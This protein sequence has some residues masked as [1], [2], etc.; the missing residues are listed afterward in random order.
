MGNPVAE[1]LC[2]E[3]QTN[4]REWGWERAGWI[5]HRARL[6]EIH[7]ND[8]FPSLDINSEII[9][10]KWEISLLFPRADWKVIKL[11]YA[12]RILAE[13][14]PRIGSSPLSSLSRENGFCGIDRGWGGGKGRRRKRL[15]TRRLTDWL[16]SNLSP[17]TV[18]LLIYR[19]Q[20][21]PRSNNKQ[22][23]RLSSISGLSLMLSFPLPLPPSCNARRTR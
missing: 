20:L 22:F 15:L 4:E 23:I 2:G 6:S 1:R 17:L 19:R 5:I 10:D 11:D 16:I 9:L 14:L 18:Q 21:E 12:E 13:S 3:R 8:Y 7:R